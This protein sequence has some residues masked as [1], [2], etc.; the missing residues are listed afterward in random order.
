MRTTFLPPLDSLEIG[1]KTTV[2][3]RSTQVASIAS[4]VDRKATIHRFRWLLAGCLF[5][6][7]L[8]KSP[9]SA[10]EIT[11]GSSTTVTASPPN[12]AGEEK[13]IHLARRTETP[14]KQSQRAA[15]ALVHKV[16]DNL[17]NGPA[18]YANVRE[19]VFVSKRDVMGV[20]TYEQ[21]GQG[22]GKYH[23][24]LTMHDGE[25]KHSLQ[26]ISDGRLAWTHRIISGQVS[27][28]R[29]DVSRLDQWVPVSE[30]TC[31]Q[32][33]RLLVG[34]WT[35]MLA[36]TEREC[37]LKIKSARLAGQPVV[38]IHA[39]LKPSERKRILD[40]TG[41]N[42]WPELHPT[43]TQIAIATVNDPKTGFGKGLPVRWEFRGDSQQIT[44]DDGTTKTQNGNLITL[45]E[46]HSIRSIDPPSGERF[47][48][49]N[50]DSDVNFVNETDRYLDLYHVKLTQRERRK[51]MR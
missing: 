47:R 12:S 20:G 29:V 40:E 3:F 19:R 45:I 26:Q 8:A 30:Q 1:R 23:L 2:V 46:M 6:P 42:T 15:V 14:L 5:F 49:D 31:G 48:F 17:A 37:I 25:G 50:R 51:Q 22:T 36:S 9:V 16:I 4:F 10:Q 27:L 35:E 32:P 24:Q 41:R 18:F 39:T 44:R 13:R 38:V 43:H 33:P 34:S 21:A 28:H 7:F 11:K